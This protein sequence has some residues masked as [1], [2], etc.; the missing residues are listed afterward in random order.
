MG[1]SFRDL[2]LKSR[3]LKDE[4]GIYD[5]GLLILGGRREIMEI[6]KHFG[7][8]LVGFQSV[9]GEGDASTGRGFKPPVGP[10][11]TVFSGHSMCH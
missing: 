6:L 9:V 11:P 3:V 1:E 10:L 8:D 7:S 2:K 5:I 4:S